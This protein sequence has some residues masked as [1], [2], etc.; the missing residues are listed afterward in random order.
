MPKDNSQGRKEELWKNNRELYWAALTEWYHKNPRLS[1]LRQLDFCPFSLELYFCCH[2]FCHSQG[3]HSPPRKFWVR[4]QQKR[5][6][7]GEEKYKT[8]EESYAFVQTVN[9]T[10]TLLKRKI[11]AYRH[12]TSPLSLS[13]SPHLSFVPQKPSTSV[14]HRDALRIGM[15]LQSVIHLGRQR[16][17]QDFGD[18]HERLVVVVTVNRKPKQTQDVVDLCMWGQDWLVVVDNCYDIKRR[19][20]QA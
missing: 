3:R 12:A 5:A 10:F 19:K 15:V 8:E 11:I 4:Q 2:S 17:P 7:E 18:T 13:L 1:S 20:R 6:V 14:Q 16:R 9:L